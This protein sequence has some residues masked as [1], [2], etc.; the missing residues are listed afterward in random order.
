MLLSDWSCAKPTP[1]TTHTHHLHRFEIHQP[2]MLQKREKK[3]T[4]LY[5]RFVLYDH[6]ANTHSQIHFKK[7]ILVP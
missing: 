3:L 1:F 4:Y 5:K 2:F 7:Y 6:E